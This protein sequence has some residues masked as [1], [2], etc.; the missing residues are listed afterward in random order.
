MVDNEESNK[1]LVLFLMTSENVILSLSF[2]KS[3]SVY[4]T[5]LIFLGVVVGDGESSFVH[6]IK[7]ST[8]KKNM[9]LIIEKCFM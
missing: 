4:K 1:V 5:N 3:S 9:V 7:L 8:D 2:E 6:E